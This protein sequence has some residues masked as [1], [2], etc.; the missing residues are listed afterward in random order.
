MDGLALARAIQ[1]DPLLA[2][3]PLILLTSL[4]HRGHA[5][6]AQEMGIRACLTKPV[7]RSQ[8]LDC[9]ATVL[10]IS[11]TAAVPPIPPT[12]QLST[13]DSRPARPPILVAE[14][15]IVNQKVAVR[16]LEKLGYHADVAAN[17]HEAV[18]ALARVPYALVLMDV[19]MPDMDGYAATAEIRQ[20]E[21]A[22]GHTP[23]I[24]MTA[25]ALEGDREKCLAAGMDD[26]L[27]KPVRAADLQA[28]LERWLPVTAQ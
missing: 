8:L 17:G 4:A 11:T 7:R 20:R 21:G 15:N 22:A 24:A 6:L 3:L 18:A 23:I 9:V 28:I 19:Q 25:N 12:Q 14:D 2:P 26:Y 10:D 13:G 16:L 1:A 5:T 27:S